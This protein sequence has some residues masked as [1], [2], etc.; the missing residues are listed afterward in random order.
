MEELVHA[1]NNNLDLSRGYKE[2]ESLI[3]NIR[4]IFSKVGSI[5]DINKYKQELEDIQREAANDNSI[6]NQMPS[7]EM[8]LEYE[9]MVLSPYI[10]KL[11][12]LTDRVEDECLP[13]YELHLLTS[14]INI[15]LS[16]I[17]E[18]TISSVIESTR[19]LVDSLNLMNTHNEK[20]KDAII[21]NAYQ[22]VYKVL[23][24]EELFDR[25][26]ILDYLNKL[27][28]PANREH[29]GRILS[30]DLGK[31]DKETIIDD[32]LRKLAT[33]R[34]GN[35]YL[36]RDIIKKLSLITVGNENSAYQE[37]RRQ[38]IVE[39]KEEAENIIARKNNLTTQLSNNKNNIRNLHIKKSLLLSK[40]ASL[41]LVPI[42]VISAGN[43]LG[44]SKSKKITEYRTL[45]RTV[46]YETGK[47]VGDVEYSF[48]EEKTPYVATILSCSP[49]RTNPVGLGYI[50]NIT[51][52]EYTAPDAADENHRINAD[53]L[54][55]NV[56]EKYT[57]IES[58]DELDKED[59]KQNTTILITESYPDGK[60]RPSTKYIIPFTIGG[61]ALSILIDAL[62]V[63][64]RISDFARSKSIIEDLNEA[65]RDHKLN[66]EQI[67][68]KLV[69]LRIDAEKT[70]EK[71]NETVKKYGSNNDSPIIDNIDTS[72]I[73]EPKSKK[74]AK[75]KA[76]F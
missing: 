64:T 2:Y 39:V 66:N 71:Y 29:I 18:D 23:L 12:N 56:K 20:R 40:I 33:E 6:N 59:S 34:L 8:Q 28:I 53:D 11:R 68:N 16:K 72:W 4:G 25:E 45:T 30:N 67:I 27:D 19:Q 32:D 46:D 61:V 62:L 1:I 43:S 21:A 5:L 57:Y 65:I 36:S 75:T 48:A 13:F 9:G 47:L 55:N 52:Y 60:T 73:I 69:E 15:Q 49:W 63:L 38:A 10:N 58:K 74:F 24:N 22:T 76:R 14:K 41:I 31:L 51:T 26:D 54:K 37:R 44:K 50:R 35:D 70:K 3:K 17:T 7:K 42:V